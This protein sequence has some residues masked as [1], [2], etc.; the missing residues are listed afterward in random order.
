MAKEKEK[1]VYTNILQQKTR[2]LEY[3]FFHH[4]YQDI[5]LLCS[6]YR[7]PVRLANS[8]YMLIPKYE[9]ITHQAFQPR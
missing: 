4:Y 8:V 6:I 7:Y 3:L 1:K 5:A 2:S 9:K